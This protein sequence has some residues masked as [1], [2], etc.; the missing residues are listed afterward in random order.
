MST[1]KTRL[2][3]RL[4]ALEIPRA[5]GE[6]VIDATLEELERPTPY[7]LDRGQTKTLEADYAGIEEAWAVMV[8]TAIEGG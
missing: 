4:E 2:R 7:M 1:M 8:R 5:V 3:A 6:L